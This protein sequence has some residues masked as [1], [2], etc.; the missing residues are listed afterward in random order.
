MPALRDNKDKIDWSLLDKYFSAAQLAEYKCRLEGSIR[1]TRD[2][3][4][5]HPATDGVTNWMSSMGTAEHDKF[6]YGCLESANRHLRSMRVDHEMYDRQTGLPHAGYV[7]LN[8]GMFWA[9]WNYGKTEEDLAQEVSDFM[10]DFPAFEVGEGA[11][12]KKPA[13][14]SYLR[15]QP[16]A[17]DFFDRPDNAEPGALR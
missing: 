14:G 11:S 17:S 16:V 3:T 2:A 13:H 7:R 15:R 12:A 9:Y 4:D 5:E 6:M 8:M 1:Y 10:G